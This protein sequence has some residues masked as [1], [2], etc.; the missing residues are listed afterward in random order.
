MSESKYNLLKLAATGFL[1]VFFVSS[2]VSA[3]AAHWPTAI[4]LSSFAISY[5]WSHNVKSIAFGG[6]WHRVCYSI[7]AG[8]GCISGVEFMSWIAHHAFH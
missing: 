4:V 7:G 6:E 8:V 1:Q 3:I 5:T 2:N